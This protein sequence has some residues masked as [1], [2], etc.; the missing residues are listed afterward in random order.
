LS[1]SF[2]SSSSLTTNSTNSAAT[3]EIR[4]YDRY[5]QKKTTS[6]EKEEAT[7]KSSTSTSSYNSGSLSSS[8]YGSSSTN[9][10]SSNNTGSSYSTSGSSYGS[11]SLNSVTKKEEVVAVEKPKETKTTPSWRTAS[12]SST[13]SAT[14]ST[15]TTTTPS[16]KKSTLASVEEKPKE[17]NVPGT[18]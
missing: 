8:S 16:W 9:T 18:I 13:T 2:D 3:P 12:L 14:T 4:S 6:V 7:P 10:S 5:V 15:T 1:S 11:S 17:A